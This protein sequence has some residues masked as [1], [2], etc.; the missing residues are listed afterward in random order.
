MGGKTNC[1]STCLC[2]SALISSSTMRRARWIY[3]WHKLIEL[4]CCHT[5]SVN[6]QFQL[7]YTVAPSYYSDSGHGSGSASNSVSNS[8][9]YSCFCSSSS[10]HSGVDHWRWKVYYPFRAHQRLAQT[11]QPWSLNINV[12]LRHV[13]LFNDLLWQTYRRVESRFIAETPDTH[14]AG[15][16]TAR[17]WRSKP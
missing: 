17:T 2:P 1:I 13:L 11:V 5:R 9:Y 12:K 4:N 14:S 8:G 16:G 15:A 10:T 7:R 3:I 6:K